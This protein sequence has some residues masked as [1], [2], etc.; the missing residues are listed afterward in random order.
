MWQSTPATGGNAHTFD[1][2][3]THVSQRMSSMCVCVE[4]HVYSH[5]FLYRLMCLYSMPVSVEKVRCGEE[6][7]A[8][9]EPAVHCV[10][11]SPT[12]THN[13]THNFVYVR[14][15]LHYLICQIK[16]SF[17]CHVK[18]EILTASRC[19]LFP[20]GVESG[21]V[22]H[23]DAHRDTHLHYVEQKETGYQ[24]CKRELCAATDG[25]NT[26]VHYPFSFINMRI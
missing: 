4:F 11:A 14:R 8:R 17:R 5:L 25:L 16:T 2:L 13:D 23:K 6:T 20:A 22:R 7:R 26:H 10:S 24:C 19:T 21:G 15:T 1:S 18:A 9:Q 12:T 3:Y